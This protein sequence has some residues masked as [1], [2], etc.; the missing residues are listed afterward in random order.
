MTDYNGITKTYG[1]ASRSFPFPHPHLGRVEAV[2]L[3]QLQTKSLPSP[4]LMHRRYPETYQTDKCKVCWRKTAD[5]THILWDCIKHT[6]AARSRTMLSRLDAAA[7][8]YDQGEQLWA[9]Q[10]V[11]GALERQ[12]PRGR[13]SC[14]FAYA[15]AAPS[16]QHGV[17]GLAEHGLRIRALRAEQMKPSSTCVFAQRIAHN[18]A[19][20][21]P[22]FVDTVCPR[23]HRETFSYLH[24]TTSKFSRSFFAS[25][26]T[27][28]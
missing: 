23:L 6:K 26:R 15:S 2:L 5:H 16:Q 28:D 8:S 21:S 1:I 10:Q 27:Q 20:C 13:G 7:K 25:L 18:A 11:L 9:V 3:R 14:Y 24:G 17:I 4:A 12:G 22:H 19:S